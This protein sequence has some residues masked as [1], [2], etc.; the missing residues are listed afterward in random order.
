MDSRSLIYQ[1]SIR[2]SNSVERANKE[3]R[4]RTKVVGVFTNEES[5]LRLISALLIEISE[6]WEIGRRCCI[7]VANTNKDI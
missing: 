4:R 5:C 6:D 1:R 3:I 7:D 2:T